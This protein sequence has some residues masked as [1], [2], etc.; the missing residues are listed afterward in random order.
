[1]KSSLERHGHF[2][3]YQ[4]RSQYNN[5]AQKYGTDI[6]PVLVRGLPSKN[7]TLIPNLHSTL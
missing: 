1:M 5:Q 7:P 6:L 2:R 4:L 3:F